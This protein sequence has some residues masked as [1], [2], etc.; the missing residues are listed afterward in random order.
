MPRGP[1][2]GRACGRQ[3]A[4]I[5]YRPRRRA[6]KE[7]FPRFKIHT[8]LPS[9]SV[10]PKAASI[11]E[12]NARLSSVRPPDRV[13]GGPCP[14]NCASRVGRRSGRSPGRAGSAAETAGGWSRRVWGRASGRTPRAG[15][16]RARPRALFLRPGSPAHGCSFPLRCCQQNA[17]MARTAASP[18]SFQYCPMRCAECGDAAPAGARPLFRKCASES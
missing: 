12:C 14:S 8:H 5:S 13:G 10:S 2:V 1:R 7:I 17:A 3:G 11:A 18:G 16:R 6:R 4:W 9:A 15:F